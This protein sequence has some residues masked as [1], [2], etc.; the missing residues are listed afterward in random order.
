MEGD[1]DSAIIGLD[2][3]V[4]DYQPAPGTDHEWRMNRMEG[5]ALGAWDFVVGDDWRTALGVVI[6]IGLTALAEAVGASA[7]WV[8]PIAVGVLLGLALRR[9]ARRQPR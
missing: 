7:W 2:V 1:D 5:F 9:E 6:A 3:H 4:D 8:L